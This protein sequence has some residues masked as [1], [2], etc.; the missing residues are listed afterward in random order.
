MLIS[1]NR[2]YNYNFYFIFYGGLF[3]ISINCQTENK[4]GQFKNSSYCEDSVLI[5]LIPTTGKK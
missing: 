2:G 4:G 5:S 1:I 3:E